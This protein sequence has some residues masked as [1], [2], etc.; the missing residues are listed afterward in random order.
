MLYQRGRARW[1]QTGRER[2]RGG[3]GVGFEGWGRKNGLPFVLFCFTQFPKRIREQIHFWTKAGL[4]KWKPVGGVRWLHCGLQQ[5][6]ATTQQHSQLLLRSSRTSLNRT[7][8][9]REL[10]NARKSLESEQEDIMGYTIPLYFD[11][12]W[13]SFF[14][15]SWLWTVTIMVVS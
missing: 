14:L 8:S 6:E 1:R 12:Y 10:W 7:D 2:Q 11:G 4:L 15:A 9:A 3:N 13:L 5:C